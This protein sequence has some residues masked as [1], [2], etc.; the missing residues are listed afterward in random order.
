MGLD[1]YLLAKKGE[2]KQENA[3]LVMNGAFGFPLGIK[4]EKEQIGYWRKAYSVN[5]FILETLDVYE[6]DVNCEELKMDLNHIEGII[7]EANFRIDE[8]YFSS[9][10]EEEDWKDTLRIMEKAKDLITNQNA[11]IYYCIWY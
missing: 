7:D 9:D 4:T 1:M 10:W 2:V 3:L 11:E 8:N 5:D 6:E